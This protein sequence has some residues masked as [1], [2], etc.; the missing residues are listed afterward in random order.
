MTA[1]QK[2]VKINDKSKVANRT[3]TAGKSVVH[4]RKHRKTKGKAEVDCRQIKKIQG[5][6]IVDI[7]KHMKT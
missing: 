6:P 2:T 4:I 7:R 3:N 5:K 1:F